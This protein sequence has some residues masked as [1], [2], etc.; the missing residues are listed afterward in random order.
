VSGPRGHA[1]LVG[2]VFPLTCVAADHLRPHRIATAG[3]STPR[4]LT[5]RNMLRLGII[6]LVFNR[7]ERYVLTLP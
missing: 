3:F 1:I 4:M 5:N 7:L 2:S 6:C